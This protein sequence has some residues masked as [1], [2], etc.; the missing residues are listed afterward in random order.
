MPKKPTTPQD[1][2]DNIIVNAAKVAS[3]A[4][5]KR[6]RVSQTARYVERSRQTSIINGH[7]ED[8]NALRDRP[9]Y[10]FGRRS[11]RWSALIA[12]FAAEANLAENDELWPT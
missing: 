4:G 3:T 9:K 12:E 8:Y 6:P 2:K 1:T 7:G 11:R 5:G 10:S